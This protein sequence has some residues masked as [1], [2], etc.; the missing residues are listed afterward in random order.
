M[1]SPGGQNFKSYFEYKSIQHNYQN[2]YYWFAWK[3]LHLFLYSA[4]E[5]NAA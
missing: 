5:A 3:S 4:V 1:F 2:N